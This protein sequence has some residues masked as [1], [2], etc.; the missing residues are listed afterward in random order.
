M[1]YIF[2]IIL[3]SQLVIKYDYIVFNQFLKYNS[4]YISQ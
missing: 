4:Q 2:T 3:I 1:I